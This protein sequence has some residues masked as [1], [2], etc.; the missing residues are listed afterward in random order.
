MVER[1]QDE[2]TR[3]GGEDEP[4]DEAQLFE[5][6]CEL[7]PEAQAQRLIELDRTHPELSSRLRRLLAIDEAYGT[8]TARS[9]MVTE[10]PDPLGDIS[11][12]GAFRLVRQ[13]GRGGMGVVYLAERRSGFEQQVAIKIMPRFAIDDA[14]RE[15]FAQERR[16]LAQLRHP[17]ICSILDGGELADGTPWLAMEYV[18]G[19]SLCAWCAR[20]RSDARERIA[21]FLQLCDAVQYAHRNLVIHRDLKDSN[22]M[23]DERGAVKLLDFG[24]AKSLATM[25]DAGHTALQDR[26]FS[27]MTAAPEQLRGERATVAVDVYALGAL[28][29]QLLCG[30]LPFERPQRDPTELQRAIL[31]TVPPRMSDVLAR[32]RAAASTTTVAPPAPS[33]GP[34]ALRGELDAIVA[35]CL[36]KDASERYA[37]IGDLARDLRAWLSGH[38]ISISRNDRLYRV[39]KFLRR[40]R[41]GAAVVAVAA[42]SVLI[43]LAVTLW[44]AS[45]LRAQRDAAQ[46]ARARSESDRD[47]A[48]AVAAFMR[49]TF[50]Q[51]DPGNA[52][53]GG[54]L[55]RE[56]IEQGKRR[57]GELDGQEDV[58]AEQALLL[59]EIDAGLGLLRESD[60][61]FRAHA[62]AIEALSAVDPD[63]RWRARLLRFSNRRELDTDGPHLDAE[64]AELKRLADTPQ[65]HVQAARQ[66]ERLAV[67]RS[68][69][70]RAARIL[71]DA[72]RRYA[73]KL[74]A[75][76]ALRLRINLGDAMLSSDRMQEAR[77]I[78]E[79]IDRDALRAHDPALQI[80]ALALIV[81]ELDA[82]VQDSLAQD[83]ADDTDA[84][85][86]R[87]NREALVQAI[88][89]RQAT[90]ERLYGSDS[91]Q[92]ASAYVW[93]VGVATDRQR[94]E[95]L[96]QKAYAIQRAKLPPVS[97]ARAYAEF[98]MA[99]YYLDLRDR[100]D[101]AEPHLAQA[102]AIGRK[103]S[104]RAHSDVAQF[105]LEWARTLNALGRH[106]VCLEQLAAPPDNPENLKAAGRLSE[107][108]LELAKAAIALRQPAQ[109]R[110][111]IATVNALWRRLG[112]PL[113]PRPA[114]ALRAVE[115]SLAAIGDGA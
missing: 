61:T 38:P 85:T 106:R 82:R 1:T 98:V 16:I 67:R 4:I 32:E 87:A 23:I 108:H 113:P 83:Q 114:E 44:Q 72:W 53:A 11:D 49:G 68:E 86:L 55:A 102:V 70:D 105:E 60:A 41:V 90:A 88:A 9:V 26:F 6:L 96:M 29:H 76:S 65:A 28:L 34:Q 36:R 17:N 66:E 71:E 104:S 40:N 93:S 7:E 89:D 97:S 52:S 19:E 12:I 50:E 58:Q 99:R 43:A 78:C 63:V 3:D 94:Q 57:L 74:D 56:L 21:L 115:R 51:A 47:R 59:A 103:V 110:A 112:K 109:A 111:E 77:R 24:I 30:V 64:L 101:L 80:L 62:P 20:H 8:H 31:D 54:L 18:P 10:L 95:A 69:F 81:R 5:T 45:E 35:H 73:T 91:I 13:I 79:G 39:G 84:A 100:P 92:A 27:P 75:P 15:R 22:V 46:Q 25:A 107:L 42:G 2:T 14:S 48:R 37:E 33:I